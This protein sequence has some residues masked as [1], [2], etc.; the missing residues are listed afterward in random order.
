MTAT[1]PITGDLIQTKVKSKEFDKNYGQIDWTV[2]LEDSVVTSDK[3]TD[4]SEN[5]K[6][7]SNDS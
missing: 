6:E 1:N 7:T 4:S 2:K 5:S 3:S